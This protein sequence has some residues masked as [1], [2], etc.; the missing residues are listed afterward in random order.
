MTEKYI[1]I[2]SNRRTISI[3]V[4]KDLEV[5]V[6]APIY[7]SR[8]TIARFVE[9][10]EDWIYRALERMEN[11]VE[12]AAST[13]T[14]SKEELSQLSKDAKAVIPLRV[15]Y[16][17]DLMC[18]DYG[19]IS[20]R[21]QRTRWGSCSSKGNLNFNCLLMLVPDD[22]RDYVIVHELCH[23]IEMNHSDKFWK[24]VENVIPDYK[25]KRKWLKENGSK[26]INSLP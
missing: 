3:E 8:R 24:L 6:R 9:E 19:R 1:V 21:S 25:E 10:K 14:F 5:I 15:A 7:A 4:T 20:I 2:K 16:F 17:A 18:V 22:V 23:R 12:A 11:K 26:Y 13:D